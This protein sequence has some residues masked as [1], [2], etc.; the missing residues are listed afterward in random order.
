MPKGGWRGG[1]KPRAWLLRS[2]EPAKLTRLEVPEDLRSDVKTIAHMFD[3]KEITLEQILR[4][5][6]L[7]DVMSINEIEAIIGE[8]RR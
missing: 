2:G 5:K 3:R 4:V 8:V 7:L 1:I 6:I